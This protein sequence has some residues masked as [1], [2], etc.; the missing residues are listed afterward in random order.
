MLTT[1][2]NHSLLAVIGTLHDR[3]GTGQSSDGPAQAGIA[4][5]DQHD[6]KTPGSWQGRIPGQP[7]RH[8]IG[9]AGDHPMRQTMWALLP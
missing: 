7:P 6:S 9:Q 5:L 4:R 1:H 2:F 3:E 8:R